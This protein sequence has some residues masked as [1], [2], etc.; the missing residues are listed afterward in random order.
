MLCDLFDCIDFSLMNQIFMFFILV[1]LVAIMVFVLLILKTLTYI[2]QIVEKMAKTNVSGAILSAWRQSQVV[3]SKPSPLFRSPQTQQPSRDDQATPSTSATL[4]HQL[5][6]RMSPDER[7]GMT[8]YSQKKDES[9]QPFSPNTAATEAAVAANAYRQSPGVVDTFNPYRY[10]SG[11]SEAP[12]SDYLRS[13]DTRAYGRTLNMSGSTQNIS[14]PFRSPQRQQMSRDDQTTPS[15][16]TSIYH[17]T[18]SRMSPVERDGVTLFSPKDESS[19][20]FS[21][22]NTFIT[23]ENDD[24]Q[25][26]PQRRNV[27]RSNE[28]D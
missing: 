20:P 8:L 26:F 14:P 11:S 4:Y 12:S 24:S 9:S 16:S 6:K 28:Y 2:Q 13:R 3:K 27:P 5:P 22:R 15:T 10:F 19:Q 25:F 17:Q 7:D 23:Y 21:P 1:I 18:P